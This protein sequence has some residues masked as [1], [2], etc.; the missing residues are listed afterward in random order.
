M[1]LLI[2]ATIIYLCFKSVDEIFGLSIVI[3][4]L[5]TSIISIVNL[6]PL[7]LS[8]LGYREVSAVFLY[9]SFGIESGIIIAAFL[10]SLIIRYVVVG[11]VLIYYN[12]KLKL[13]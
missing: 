12:N 11:I 6:I 7:S 13:K 9:G 1:R 5:I 3:V 2:T 8:G 4:I 10:Y